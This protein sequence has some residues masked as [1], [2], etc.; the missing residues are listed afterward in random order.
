VPIDPGLHRFPRSLVPGRGGRLAPVTPDAIEAAMRGLLRERHAVN[1]LLAR[2]RT[3][4]LLIVVDREHK[5]EIARR[6]AGIGGYDASRTIMCVV[7][8]RGGT[9]DATASISCDAPA[10]GQPDDACEPPS[11]GVIRERIEINLN[12]PKLDHLATIIDPLVVSDLPTVLWCPHRPAKRISSLCRLVNVVL[13]DSDQEPE[14][15]AGLAAASELARS[16]NVVDL[17]SL[18]T[19][20]WRG[21]LATSVD[22]PEHRAALEQVREIAVRHRDTAT[23]SALLFAGWLASRL[24]WQPARRRRH[25]AERCGHGR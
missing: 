24:R 5:T 11:A 19:T 4:N 25:R 3:L 6:L 2:A 20:P 10:C 23:A 22:P 15:K 8:E 9:L 1:Q 13:L 7:E 18:R 14:P 12:P 21:R 17:A 16:A